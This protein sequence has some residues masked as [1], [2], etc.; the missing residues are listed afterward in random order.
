MIDGRKLRSRAT[1]FD[2]MSSHSNT[3]MLYEYVHNHESCAKSCISRRSLPMRLA[4]RAQIPIVTPLTV[5]EI[6]YITSKLRA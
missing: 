6:T 2:L 5:L 1:T 4:A 3:S